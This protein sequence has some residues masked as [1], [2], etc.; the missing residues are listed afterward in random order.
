MGIM[1]SKH[2]RRA[3]PINRSQNAFAWGDRYGVFNTLNPNLRSEESI[4]RVVNDELVALTTDHTLPELLPYIGQPLM[5]QYEA[6]PMEEN[7]SAFHCVPCTAFG[8]GTIYNPVP[9][10]G[11]TVRRFLCDA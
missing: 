7:E 11:R 8:A 10:V 2:S 1:K 4:S 9:K 5:K 3:L 6:V